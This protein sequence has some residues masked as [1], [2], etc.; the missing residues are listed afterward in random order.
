[1]LVTLGVFPVVLLGTKI[2]LYGRARVGER[3]E[4][5]VG[6]QLAV[7]DHSPHKIAEL[8]DLASGATHAEQ[9]PRET[10]CGPTVLLRVIPPPVGV[11][12]LVQVVE[13]PELCP[14]VRV[15]GEARDHV[16]HRL[17]SVEDVQC[18]VGPQRLGVP[19]HRELPTDLV[20][21]VVHVG[22]VERGLRDVRDVTERRERDVDR[23]RVRRELEFARGPRNDMERVDDK[24]AGSGAP[25]RG[26]R[27]EI[28]SVR[29]V[30]V[31]PV[32]I[33]R[34]FPERGH[35]LADT[36]VVHERGSRAHPE[37]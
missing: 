14:C 4:D 19:H 29:R 11:R 25:G 27:Q 32:R 7:D 24:R 15:L 8:V 23:L 21:Y 20:E 5:P 37:D 12:D 33:V 2:V 22:R 30:H 18:H 1:M 28:A 35:N 26:L 9:D 17:D 6:V 3:P 31:A 10:L 13:D 34:P 36:A 16:Q